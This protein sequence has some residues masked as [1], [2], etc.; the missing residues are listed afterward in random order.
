MDSLR[1]LLVFRVLCRS[2]FFA[3]VSLCWIGCATVS[4][5]LQTIDAVGTLHQPAVNLQRTTEEP[6][7]RVSP[8]LSVNTMTERTG[9]FPGHTNVNKDGVYAV[10]TTVS[11]NEME[12]TESS[13]NTYTFKGQNF[14]WQMPRVNAGASFDIDLSE[15]VALMLGVGVASINNEAFWSARTGLGFGFGTEKIQA[16]CDLALTWE[17]IDASASYVQRATT[18]LSN[19]TYVNFFSEEQRNMRMG[20]YGA[21]TLQ[22]TGDDLVYY[23]Q[24]ALGYTSLMKLTY[25]VGNGSSQNSQ[26]ASSDD[27]DP[28]KMKFISITPGIAFKVG[29]GIRLIAGLRMTSDTE[30]QA[31]NSTF[32]FTPLCELE[33]SF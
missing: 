31:T 3:L 9:R 15:R 10:D 22:S 13:S 4:T 6:G 33:F 28:S 27:N 16:R 14:T 20:Y 12:L 21:L 11:G 24:F 8:W 19:T 1:E 5:N 7:I 25:P 29:E 30:I 17:T 23:A 18:F 26:D 2:L 32:L